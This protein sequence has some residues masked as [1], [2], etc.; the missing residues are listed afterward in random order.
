MNSTTMASHEWRFGTDETPQLH[1]RCRY[2]D[3]TISHDA[4]PGE[5][6]V[7]ART[8][9]AFDPAT[10]E[11][12]TEGRD[13]FVTLPPGRDADSPFGFSFQLGSLSWD[14]GSTR[15]IAVDVHVP[16]GADLDVQVDGGDLT[17]TGRSG[18]AALQTGGGDI[19]LEQADSAQVATQGGDISADHLARA[20]LRT[21]GGDIRVGR[22]GEGAVKTGGGDVT[23]HDLGSGRVSTGGGDVRVLR[24]GGDVSVHTGAGDVTL[25]ECPGASEVRTGAGDVRVEATA[26][27]VDVKTGAGDITVTVPPTVP[28]WQDLRSSFGDV[29]SQIGSRGEPADGEPY[30][31]V[32]AHTGTGDVRLTTGSRGAVLR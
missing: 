5:V 7:T 27:R 2:A 23:V 24:C 15:R 32:T 14:V 13:I 31:Q 21:A 30:L 11:T 3:V 17:C 9:A 29:V 20:E 12:R 16:E 4:G 26:G 6:V 22:I 25:N 1:L 8:S 18:R 10:V 28:V 19:T